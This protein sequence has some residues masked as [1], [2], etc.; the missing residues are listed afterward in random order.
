MASAIEAIFSGVKEFNSATQE[1]EGRVDR[2]TM[3]SLK[4]VQNKMKTAIRANL[5]G[6]PRWTQKGNNK[7]TGANFQVSGTTGQHN[8]PRSGGPGRM[9][10]VL[11]KGVGSVK[12]PQEVNGYFSGGVGIGAPPNNVK[13]RMLEAKYPYFA[14]AIAKVEPEVSKIYELS[15]IHI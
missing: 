13:K 12:K 15:L 8:F 3:N 9:T 4:T 5:R 14:P 1:I 11:Y 7:I 6:N 10:G 2:A